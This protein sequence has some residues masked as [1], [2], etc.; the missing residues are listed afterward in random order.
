MHIPIV[1]MTASFRSE[2]KPSFSVPEYKVYRHLSLDLA[3]FDELMGAA[4][5]WPDIPGC[6]YYPLGKYRPHNGLS[7]TNS[8]VLKD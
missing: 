8:W 7:P 4:G 6:S 3:K 2:K 1:R 5:L